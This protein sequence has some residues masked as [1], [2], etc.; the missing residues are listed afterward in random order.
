MPDSNGVSLLFLPCR[1]LLFL[2]ST[3]FLL[4]VFSFLSL[5]SCCL[6]L[7]YESHLLENY[8]IV[9]G[10]KSMQDFFCRKG[11]KLF[12][13]VLHQSKTWRVLMQLEANALDP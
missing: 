12:L 3:D 6:F 1:N 5:L 4:A 8:N 10:K 13:L 2:G 9:R 11:I 7:L